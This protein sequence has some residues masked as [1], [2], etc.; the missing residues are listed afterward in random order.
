[1]VEIVCMRTGSGTAAF[2]FEVDSRKL[3]A[4]RDG[5]SSYLRRKPKNGAN[6]ANMAHKRPKW[7]KRG[8]N[9][10]TEAVILEQQPKC[11]GRRRNTGTGVE[12]EMGVRMEGVSPSTE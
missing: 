10:G 7:R 12:S 1:M 5:S 4:T 6:E 11:W 3:S 8:R 9:A 2:D